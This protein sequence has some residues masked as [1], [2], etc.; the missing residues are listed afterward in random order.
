MKKAITSFTAAVL[1][2]ALLFLC[3]CEKSAQPE[4]K[5]ELPSFGSGKS[6]EKPTEEP[7][8]DAKIKLDSANAAV[9]AASSMDYDATLEIIINIDGESSAMY[10]EGRYRYS[11]YGTDDYKA[12]FSYKSS[13]YAGD[14][15]TNVYYTD[16]KVFENN[17][18][19][20]FRAEISAEDFDD[21]ISSDLALDEPLYEGFENH[22]MTELD[23]GGCRISYSSGSDDVFSYVEYI[24][25]GDDILK[26][27][28]LV[29]TGEAELD[30]Q[31]AMTAERRSF[32]ID[33]ES[34]GVQMSFEV[35]ETYSINSLDKPL[36]FTIP[37]SDS[38]YQTISDIRIPGILFGA[39]DELY[40]AYEVHAQRSETRSFQYGGGY[41]STYS[42]ENEIRM[43]F[44]DTL[45][46][47]S[48]Y[49][50]D[51]DYSTWNGAQYYDGITYVD[52]FN[53]DVVSDTS[54]SLYD[55]YSYI[56][57]FYT[58]YYVYPEDVTEYSL[59]ETDDEYIIDCYYTDIFADI[60]VDYYFY[61]ANDIEDITLSAE[62]ANYTENRGRIVID[63]DSGAV[64]RHEIFVE[65]TY[66]VEGSELIAEMFCRIDII[67]LED[68]TVEK[69]PQSAT[70]NMV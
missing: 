64:L 26:R 6:G 70:G 38:S 8:S 43:S 34:D 17:E 18:Y 39:Y 45:V 31:G 15:S 5:G 30:A 41:T 42:E 52:D 3:G 28:S 35:N 57:Y 11:D 44:L 9:D 50:G 32:T 58:E 68:V 16:G 21:Y 10:L 56:S 12:Y 14:S 24:L 63:K 62:S 33:G 7:L 67:S 20:K 13:T 51:S 69:A 1:A 53:G 19:G 25:G 59:T 27:D 60:D 55:L 23:S 65:A 40:N 36:S 47:S 22:K 4:K 66:S 29:F 2:L 61:Y 37:E 46:F 48:I 49:S 54:Y